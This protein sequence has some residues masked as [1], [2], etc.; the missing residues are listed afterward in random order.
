MGTKRKASWMK[1]EVI[2]KDQYRM[3]DGIARYSAAQLKKGANKS[4]Y[5]NWPSTRDMMKKVKAFGKQSREAILAMLNDNAQK[6]AKA[7]A[8]ERKK[9]KKEPLSRW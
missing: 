8:A 1:R 2:P 4:P 7:R 9:S 6:V 3:V 5:R